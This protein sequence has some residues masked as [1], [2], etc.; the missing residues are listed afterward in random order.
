MEIG[1]GTPDWH[2]A[3]STIKLQKIIWIY[4]PGHAGVKGNERA[5]KLAGKTPPLNQAIY[6]LEDLK[7]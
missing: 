7:S 6:A 5:D 1:I 2:E 4:C 3:M